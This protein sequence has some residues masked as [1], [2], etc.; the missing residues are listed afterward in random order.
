MPALSGLLVF[1]TGTK[2]HIVGI[3]LTKLADWRYGGV[4]SSDDL[5][6]DEDDLDEFGREEELGFTETPTQPCH[7]GVKIGCSECLQKV[8]RRMQHKHTVSCTTT[9]HRK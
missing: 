5:L 7:V 8:F 9:N 4:G 6:D 3:F 2:A 1:R